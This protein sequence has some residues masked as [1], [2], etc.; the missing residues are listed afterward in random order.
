[1]IGTLVKLNN[2]PLMRIWQ[3]YAQKTGYA[4][5]GNGTVTPISNVKLIIKSLLSGSL[6]KHKDKMTGTNS[7]IR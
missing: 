2:G 1:M 7:S 4:G 3:R 5:F 6:L